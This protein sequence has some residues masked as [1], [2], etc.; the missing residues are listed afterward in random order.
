MDTFSSFENK[1]EIMDSAFKTY[2]IIIL[3]VHMHMYIKDIFT[4]AS[5]DTLPFSVDI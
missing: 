3:Y 4:N 1:S 5:V 2:I